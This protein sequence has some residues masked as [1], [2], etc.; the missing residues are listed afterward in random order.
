MLKQPIQRSS[1]LFKAAYLLKV[2]VHSQDM[3]KKSRG[4]AFKENGIFL[5]KKGSA[6]VFLLWF[7]I[8]MKKCKKFVGAVFEKID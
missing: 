3:H 5:K 6:V 1:T 2:D 7:P 4:G 8:F